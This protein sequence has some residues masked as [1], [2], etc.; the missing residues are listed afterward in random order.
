M[1]PTQ[2]TRGCPPALHELRNAREDAT[3]PMEDPFAHTLN[4]MVEVMEHVTGNT[5]YMEL[6]RLTK[7]IEL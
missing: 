5:H 3:P 7:R 2:S 6:G 4:G 1:L